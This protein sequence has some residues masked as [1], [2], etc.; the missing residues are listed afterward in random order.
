MPRAPESGPRAAA[1][2][3]TWV[4]LLA[5]GCL[6]PAGRRP[7]FRLSGEEVRLVDGHLRFAADVDL[8]ALETR[9]WYR[10]PHSVTVTGFLHGDSLY[11]PSRSPREKRWVAHVLRDP[12]VRLRAGDRILRGR[13]VRVE[14]P[15]FARQLEAAFARKYGRPIAPVREG[16]APE[17]WFFRFVPEAPR[18]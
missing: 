10:I 7:G 14:D 13:L 4:A 17:V 9:T 3:V 18:P 8:F 2:L 16:L 5:G 12:R 15:H 6:D 11:I 1:L